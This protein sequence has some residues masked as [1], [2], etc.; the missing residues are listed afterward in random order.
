MKEELIKKITEAINFIKKE[1]IN[2]SP[3]YGIILGSGLG[4]IAETVEEKIVIP[5]HEVPNMPVSNIKGH[6]GN[7]VFGYLEQKPVVVMNGRI[8]YYEGYSMQE[9][10]FPIRI[11]HKLGVKYLIITAAVG[12]I[13]KRLLLKPSD[14]VIVKDHINLIGDNPLR[15]IIFEEFGEVFVDLSNVYDKELI[16]LTKTIAKE[17]NLKIY[18]GIYLATCGPSYET[19]AEIKAF[20][21]LGA[22][23]VGMSLVPEAVVAKQANMKI[24]GICYVTNLASGFS[25]KPLSHVEVLEIATKVAYKLNMLIKEL[26]KRLPDYQ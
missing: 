26:I 9:V 25:S 17:K 5:Y 22:D 14:I 16:K 6:K 15:G 2:I 1:T 24:L 13:R 18:E 23:V 12:A 21:K 19:P 11:M 10:T 3:Q 20:K 7:F 4:N 8:H